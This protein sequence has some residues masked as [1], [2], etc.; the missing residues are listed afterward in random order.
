VASEDLRRVTR[1]KSFVARCLTLEVGAAS[2]ALAAAACGATSGLLDDLPSRATD[3]SQPRDAHEALATEAGDTAHGMLMRDAGGSDAR[4]RLQDAQDA[5]RDSTAAPR[6]D[7]S[8]DA[9]ADRTAAID[10]VA[11]SAADAFEASADTGDASGDGAACDPTSAFGAPV[12][13]PDL[14]STSR[15]DGLS[16]SP[17]AR[18]AYLSSERLS[19]AGNDQIF[20]ATKAA[21][22][23]TF[24]TPSLLAGIAPD[25]GSTGSESDFAPRISADGLRLYLTSYRGGSST[26]YVATRTDVTGQFQAPQLVPG[27]YSPAGSS[28]KDQ[29]L[30]PD[31]TTMYF[32][33][34]RLGPQSLFRAIKDSGG[35]FGSP[36]E[37]TELLATPPA[38]DHSPVVSADQLTIFFASNRSGA[39][40]IWMAVRSSATAPFGAPQESTVLNIADDNY[41]QWLPSDE[42]TLYIAAGPYDAMHFYKATR[43]G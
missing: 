2:V 40:R 10:S 34:N 15:D 33:S 21:A 14:S 42:C 32:S 41:P 22:G 39:T 17:N 37:I 1:G 31:E 26:I 38:D 29:Y 24:N 7:A 43:G 30:T 36:T 19:Y 20:V 35:T 5:R 6:Q 9:V 25:A 4:D 8:H 12:A 18:T 28:D 23:D 27:I 16:L 11:D 3:A 13:I